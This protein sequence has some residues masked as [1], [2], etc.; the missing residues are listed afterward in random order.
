MATN[1]K[2]D[3]QLRLWGSNGQKSLQNASICCLGSDAYASESLKNLVLPGV[4][5][6]TIVDDVIVSEVDTHSNFFVTSEAIGKH[7]AKSVLDNLLELNGDVRGD[8]IIN[9]PV[10]YVSSHLDD[11]V[12]SGYSLIIVANSLSFE[13]QSKLVEKC[14]KFFV[15]VIIIDASGL[16]CVVQNHFEALPILETHPDSEFGDL[17]LTSPF[18]TLIDYVKSFDFDS[19]SEYDRHHVPW[20]VL[21]IKIMQDAHITSPQLLPS[22][23]S[24]KAA[25][26]ANHLEPFLNKY[27]HSDS[28]NASEAR[29]F[30]WRSFIAPEI[31]P[32]LQ[33]AIESAPSALDNLLSM[34]SG[35]ISGFSCEVTDEKVTHIKNEVHERLIFWVLMKALSIFRSTHNSLLPLS[36]VVQDM[37]SSTS[38]FVRLQTIFK[39]KSIEDTSELKEIA[40]KELETALAS[41]NIEMTLSNVESLLSNEVVKEFVLNCANGRCMGTKKL[42]SGD[43]QEIFK[44]AA[45][46]LEWEMNENL[47]DMLLAFLLWKQAQNSKIPSVI[48]DRDDAAEMDKIVEDILT[49]QNIKFL[50]CWSPSSQD[51]SCDQGNLFLSNVGVD[52][53]KKYLFEAVRGKGQVLHSVAAVVGGVV[54]QESM[55]VITKHFI[56]LGGFWCWDAAH[57]RGWSLPCLKD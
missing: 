52:R 8:A 2:Y 55:K 33:H 47:I 7:R 34:Y 39:Q 11:E 32:E 45:V 30:A 6:I 16:L 25:F 18:P 13:L 57:A 22:T 56:P 27:F 24:E 5:F 31:T 38:N 1:N 50:N 19:M 36:G 51:N 4:G 40:K 37:H 12:L 48:D 29:T 23:A 14:N 35:F 21:L 46:S 15:P 9:S 42:F 26:R 53:M 3:R 10:L 44:E 17:R 43:V 54:A 49:S 20:L 41:H 28:E